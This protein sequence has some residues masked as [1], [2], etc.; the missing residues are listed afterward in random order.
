VHYPLHGSEKRR[1]PRA[2][3]QH[4]AKN[5]DGVNAQPAFTRPVDIGIKAQ[6]ER[7]FVQRERRAHSV[8][9]RH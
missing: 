2:H 8:T 6:P 4:C 7:E 5:D 3:S 1:A 9:N